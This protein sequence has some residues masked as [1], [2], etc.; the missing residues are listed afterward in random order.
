[1]EFRG[2]P[3]SW[4]PRASRLEGGEG[5]CTTDVRFDV[6]T[7]GLSQVPVVLRCDAPTHGGLSAPVGD[8]DAAVFGGSAMPSDAGAPMDDGATVLDAGV[9]VTGGVMASDPF[10]HDACESCLRDVCVR[11]QSLQ[12]VVACILITG[13]DPEIAHLLCE[14]ACA[15]TP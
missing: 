11:M 8:L 4:T 10:A 7:A 1:M 12:T 3:L 6:A 2:C 9:S 15:A 13:I 5:L 14:H